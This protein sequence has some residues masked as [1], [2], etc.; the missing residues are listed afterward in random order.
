VAIDGNTLVAGAD[1]SAYVFTRS[2][3]TWTERVKLT[4]SDG[5]NDD[6]FGWCVAIDADIIVISAPNSDDRGPYTGSAYVFSRSDNDDWSEQA[7]LIAVD[8]E[9]DDTFGQSMAISSKSVVIGAYF[10]DNGKAGDKGS[11]YVFELPY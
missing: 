10:D 11:A 8:G 7:K 5:A 4:S 2:G 6:A 3:T 1:Q 9:T